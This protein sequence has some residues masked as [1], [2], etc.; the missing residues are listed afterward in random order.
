MDSL[1]KAHP[2]ARF[3]LD[4]ALTIHGKLGELE[5]LH[6]INNIYVSYKSAP[7]S[8]S[9]ILSQYVHS[10]MDIY[11]GKGK[12]N[13]NDVVPIIKPIEYLEEINSMGKEPN[14]FPLISEKYNDQLVIVFAED[15]EDKLSYLTSD[16]LDSFSV[17]KDSLK[18]IAYRNLQQKLPEVTIKGGGGLYM[19]DAGGVYEASLLLSENMWNKK[20]FNVSGDLVIAI[21]S[22]D[23]LI[24]TG[25]K[26]TKGIKNVKEMVADWYNKQSYPISEYLYKWTGKN[27][28]LFESGN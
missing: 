3:E 6:Y 24:V 10:T 19:V 8:I 21:P 16:Y 22:R 11:L 4:S 2:E 7:D 14:K 17:S 15:K 1:K 12:I 25:S 26:D 27:F 9:N 5:F 18:A 23:F 20:N 13:I 28:E